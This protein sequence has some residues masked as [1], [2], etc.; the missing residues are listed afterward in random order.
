MLKV[1]KLKHPENDVFFSSDFHFNHNRPWIFGD[2]GFSNI[3]EHDNTLI[4]NFNNRLSYNSILFHLGDF[5]F[6]DSTGDLFLEY[7]RRLKFKTFFH[8]WGNHVS[9]S[10]Q[11]YLKVLK[12]DF[13]SAFNE[14]NELLYEVYPLVHHLN[15]EQS[16][17]FLPQ[18]VETNI[19]GHNFVLSHY[20]IISFNSQSHGSTCLSGH[21]HNN[22]KL[23]GRR[24]D[25]GVDQFPNLINMNEARNL[26]KDRDLDILDHHKVKSE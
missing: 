13:P 23:T 14:N 4:K 20:P 19:N 9:G 3:E 1:L 7:V 25:V 11:F 24:L 2:R 18:Y 21:C 15:S 26:L 10:R 12:D 22:I 8:L 17:V 16:I 5:I 6:N